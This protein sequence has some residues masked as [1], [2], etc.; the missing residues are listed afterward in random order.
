MPL[1]ERDRR[2]A[3]VVI[4][5]TVANFVYYCPK[6]LRPIFVLS[7]SWY[8]FWLHQTILHIVW[9]HQW[10]SNQTYNRTITAMGCRQC[11]PFSVVQL[12]G[13]HCQKP[14]CRNGV[15]DTFGLGYISR[16]E[17]FFSYLLWQANLTIESPLHKPTFPQK[18]T[19][20][21]HQISPTSAVWKSLKMLLN[22][23][24]S[25]SEFYCVLLWLT[26]KS[27]ALTCLV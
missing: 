14:H 20:N 11:L 18:F 15:V 2:I 21:K 12:K 17:Q 13:K 4:L 24:C 8:W 3:L 16:I 19:V 26:I 23:T 9:V 1:T 6:I 25:C 10:C 22:E 5:I 27:Q 7:N